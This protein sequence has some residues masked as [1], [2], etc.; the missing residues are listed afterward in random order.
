MSSCC[1][2]WFSRWKLV[3][4]ILWS[5]PR[6]WIPRWSHSIFIDAMLCWRSSW[7]AMSNNGSEDCQFLSD[8]NMRQ[9]KCRHSPSHLSKSMNFVSNFL[10]A[11]STSIQLMLLLKSSV[12][13]FDDDQ[14]MHL[15]LDEMAMHSLLMQQSHWYL[16]VFVSD[17][18]D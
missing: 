15:Q 16:L 10:M 4:L 17:G 13:Q 18:L 6:H 7:H 8:G 2:R 11:A 3:L 12:T 14:S 5:F 9:L 1:T